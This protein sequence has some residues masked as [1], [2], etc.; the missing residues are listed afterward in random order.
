ME[1]P[2]NPASLPADSIPA[3]DVLLYEDLEVGGFHWRWDMP[4]GASQCGWADSEQAAQDAAMQA[5]EAWYR[6]L[7]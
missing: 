1:Q 6:S 7:A 2:A 5:I 3:G 4:C